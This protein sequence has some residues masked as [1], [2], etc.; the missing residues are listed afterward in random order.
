MRLFLRK[1]FLLKKYMGTLKKTNCVK[2]FF[3]SK[4][5]ISELTLLQGNVF[6]IKACR[7]RKQ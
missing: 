1:W 4:E 2:T 5:K 6:D 3:F 7:L